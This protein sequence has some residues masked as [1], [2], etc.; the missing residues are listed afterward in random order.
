VK[1]LHFYKTY[2]PD[3]IG[4]VEQ[5]I[6][7]LVRKTTGLGATHEV[8]SL[9][10][11]KTKKTVTVDGHLVHRCRSDF[12]IASTPFSISAFRWFKELAKEADII[13]YHFPYPFADV[14]H[15]AS[16]INKPSLVSY[17]SDI[18]KQ[19]YLLKLYRPLMRYFL[20]H[21]DHIVAASPNY[22]KSSDGLSHFKHKTSVIPYGLEKSAYPTHF[23]ERLEFWREKCGP[24]FFLFIGVLRYY[25]G[26]HILIEAARN[27][28][29]PV[30]IAG[31]G[32]IERVLKEQT[33]KLG[34]KNIHFVGFISE[35]DKA[36]L[37][38]LC[39]A[40][41]FPSHLRS[42]AFGISLLEGAMYG[43]PL[44]SCEI[45]TG[46]TYINLDKKTGLVVPP[47]EPTALREAM[48]YLWNNSGQ[49][50]AMGK[51]AEERYRKL[52]T[53][54]EMA[55]SYFALYE[56]LLEAKKSSGSLK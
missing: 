38:E 3:T 37:L 25:K 45:G 39:Y 14:L 19:K 23:S 52:F 11:G 26:L 28:Q 55:K 29:Y 12:E 50:Q 9:T 30:V 56:K 13:H 20:T 51:R 40:F 5:V 48:D 53:A 54:K 27:A 46:T 21:V 15:M 31:A 1:I 17:H 10:P 49:A 32:P 44:I 36:A 16:R 43:K 35:E 34:V 4:G 33:T 42:E 18:I 41:V 24:R 22:L 8:L 6:N 7:Q 2:L 47:S